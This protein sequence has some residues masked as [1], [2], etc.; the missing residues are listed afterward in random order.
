M[1]I[2]LKILFF[3]DILDSAE[4]SSNKCSNYFVLQLEFI[5][6]NIWIKYEAISLG[7]YP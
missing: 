1:F 3:R 4:S 6:A 2:S 5:I 7:S